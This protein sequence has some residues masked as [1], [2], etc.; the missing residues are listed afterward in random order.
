MNIKNIAHRYNTP[1]YLI[2][3]LSAKK[4]FFEIKNSFPSHTVIAYATKANYSASIIAL[5][6]TLKLYFDVFTQGELDLLLRLGIEPEKIIYTSVS[7]TKE[8]FEFAVSK[9]VR[10]F[11]IGSLQGFYNLNAVVKR[12]TKKADI[13]LRIQPIKRVVAG[14]ST[15]GIKSKFGMT[16]TQSINILNMLSKT[17]ELCFK[18]FHF[19][20]GTQIMSPEFYVKA[21]NKTLEFVKGREIEIEILDIGGGYPFPYTPEIPKIYEF[22]KKIRKL[23]EKWRKEIGRF[24]LFIE[25]GRALVANTTVL[26]TKVVNIKELYRRKIII[27]DASDEMIS[28]KRHKIEKNIKILSFSKEAEKYSIAGNLCHSADWII[29]NPVKLPKVKINDLIVFENVGAYVINH[30]IPYGLRKKPKILVLKNHTLIEEKHP[31]DLIKN[32]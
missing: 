11:V 30:N 21:I 17:K 9:G 10:F 20:L 1:F 29:E 28:V 5:F 4:S 32:F 12:K 7:E 22:G 25:P 19:H 27:I 14:T 2:D 8:E 18:G 26:V 16:F 31:F 24:I 6:K 3:P 23:I 15:S 13:L